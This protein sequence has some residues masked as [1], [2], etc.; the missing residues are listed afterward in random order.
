MFY[1]FFAPAF[2]AA[3]LP[4]SAHAQMSDMDMKPMPNWTV[5]AHTTLTVVADD[6]QGPRGGSKTF[7]EGMSMIMASRALNASSDLELQAMLS[8]DPFMG[9]SGYPLLLQTGE[10]ADGVTPLVD[11]QHPHD[12]FMGLNATL[13]HRFGDDVSGFVRAGWPGENGFGPQVF[14]HRPSGEN[15]PTAPITHHWFDS[16]HIT[17]GVVTAGLAKGPFQLEVSGFTGREPDQHRFNLDHPRFDSAAVRLSWRVT[18]D[19]SAQASW[20]HV[21]SPDQLEPDVNLIQKSVSFAYE[22][23][24]AAGT[25]DSTLAYGRKIASMSAYKPSDALLF[26]NTFH[27]NGPWLGLLRHERVYNDELVPGSAWWVAKTEIGIAR[28][29]DLGHDMKLGVG[30]VRQFNAVPDA[31]KTVYGG[32]PDGTVAFLRLMQ[33]WVPGMSMPGMSMSGMDM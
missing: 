24:F 27:F 29:F 14:M 8:P 32:H 30:V 28:E 26:E 10:T 33:Q 21:I 22:H 19:L 3:L 9:K 7:V 2:A 15:F 11:R 5:M 25:L 12:L 4:V 16:G 17:M 20:A 1:R 13:R 23:R 6:Q 18:P 31:L